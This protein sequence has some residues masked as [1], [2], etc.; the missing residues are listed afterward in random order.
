MPTIFENIRFAAC[1]TCFENVTV[2]MPVPANLKE[3]NNLYLFSRFCNSRYCEPGGKC[4]RPVLGSTHLKNF[5]DWLVVRSVCV[6]FLTLC[7]SW[8][9]QT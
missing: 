6:C 4:L 5:C 7:A 3:E 9:T 2:I 8:L 1:M